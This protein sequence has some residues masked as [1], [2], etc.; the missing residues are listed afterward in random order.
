MKK[1]TLI[2]IVVLF[3]S[4]VQAQK[5]E[6]VDDLYWFYMNLDIVKY[7]LTHS[8]IYEFTKVYN[9]IHI[10]N[11]KKFLKMQR[12]KMKK[13]F[14]AIGPFKERI[15]AEKSILCYD[16]KDAYKILKKENIESDYYLYTTKI[17][18]GKKDKALEFRRIPT[19]INENNMKFFIEVLEDAKT[20][21]ILTIGPFV[22]ESIA[23]K[24][25]LLNKGLQK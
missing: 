16:N 4:H 11:S 15:T 9:K 18:K 7:E 19:S 1:I 12:K 25:M 17:V 23:K 5:T 13:G 2:L 14:V 6:K 22:D 20:F 21:L 8:S 3:A 10:G 24:S